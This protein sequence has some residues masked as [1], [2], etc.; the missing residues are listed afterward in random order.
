MINFSKKEKIIMII[1]VLGILIVSTGRYIINQNNKAIIYDNNQDN[2]HVEVI[3]NETIDPSGEKIKE[4]IEIVVDICGEVKNQGV[5]K[6]KE[7][8]RV[9]D[10]VNAAG[11]LL[12]YAD[13]KKVNMARILE[14]GEQIIIPKIGETLEEE[15]TVNQSSENGAKININKASQSEL[16]GLNGI[17]AVLAQ[18]IIKYREENGSFKNIEDIMKVSGIG[19][20]KFESFKDQISSK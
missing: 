17:G 3:N 7:G 15:L 19:P 4:N 14:D 16:E 2:S 9:I 18:K 11:G 13:R 20:K 8:D 6:L 12:E 10:A 5:V 1:L